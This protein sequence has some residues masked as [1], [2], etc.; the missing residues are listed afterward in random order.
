MYP[1]LPFLNRIC[2]NDYRLPNSDI[3]IENGTKII[4]PIQGLH[5][6]PEY[7]PEP[8]QFHPERFSAENKA[9]IPPYTFMPFG[10]GPRNCIGKIFLRLS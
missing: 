1:P 5:Y 7:F 4:F 8:Y 3:V 9:Q 6:D 2:V 10:D